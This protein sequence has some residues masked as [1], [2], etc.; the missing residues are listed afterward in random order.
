MINS[1]RLLKK[2]VLFYFC[3]FLFQC[4]ISPILSTQ[5]SNIYLIIIF[6]QEL[7]KEELF[8]FRIDKGKYAYKD[9]KMIAKDHGFEADGYSFVIMGGFPK[10]LQFKGFFR[11]I[12]LLGYFEGID[13]NIGFKKIMIKQ[14]DIIA[15]FRIENSLPI[16]IVIKDQEIKVGATG[17]IPIPLSELDNPISIKARNPFYK[18]CEYEEDR[19]NISN[20]LSGKTIIIAPNCNRVQ[21]KLPQE[22]IAENWASKLKLRN[23]ADVR[24]R[25]TGDLTYETLLSPGF[26][27]EELQI[28]GFLGI[29][30]RKLLVSP[31]EY[32][33][34]SNNLIVKLPVWLP[35][36]ARCTIFIKDV[37]FKPGETNEIELRFSELNQDMKIRPKDDCT[38]DYLAITPTLDTIYQQNDIEIKPKQKE[39]MVL[40]PVEFKG[41]KETLTGKI[42]LIGCGKMDIYKN[43]TYVAK[44]NDA[45][46]PTKIELP[47]FGIVSL[48]EEPNEDDDYLPI[49]NQFR[50]NVNISKD[51]SFDYKLGS[52]F[53]KPGVETETMLT[54]DKLG[55]ELKI[56]AIDAPDQYDILKTF[57]V[58]DIISQKPIILFPPEVTPIT[59]TVVLPKGFEGVSL[60]GKTI[61]YACKDRQEPEK[62]EACEPAE[63]KKDSKGNKLKRTYIT[64]CPGNKN[65]T[66]INIPG[67]TPAQIQ[68]RDGDNYKTKLKTAL[69]KINLPPNAPCSYEIAGQTI[70][71]GETKEIFLPIKDL[72]KSFEVK[73]TDCSYT[74]D[75]LM[76]GFTLESA[77]KK[78]IQQILI[79]IRKLRIVYPPRFPTPKLVNV[80]RKIFGKA[81]GGDVTYLVTPDL[82]GQ[83]IKLSW[84]EG[85]NEISKLPVDLTSTDPIKIALED[86]TYRWPFKANDP[87]LIASANS[88]SESPCEAEPAYRVQTIKFHSEN[89][90]TGWYP[91]EKLTNKTMPDLSSAN[92]PKNLGLPTEVDFKLK[93]DSTNTAYKDVI[94]VHRQIKEGAAMDYLK[95]DYWQEARNRLPAAVKSDLK[96]DPNSK[97]LFYPSRNACENADLRQATKDFYPFIP[98]YLGN[99]KADACTWATIVRGDR[100]LTP[101]IQGREKDGKIIFEPKATTISGRR[102]IIAIA[103]SDQLVQN[104]IGSAIK[105]GIIQWLQTLKA[106]GKSLPFNIFLLN[107]DRQVTTQLSG[108]EMLLLQFSEIESRID[109][110]LIFTGNG[111]N[112]LRCLNTIKRTVSENELK[113]NE[114][115]LFTDSR[116]LPDPETTPIDD[117]Q[118]PALMSWKLDEV[119]V[120]VYT[121]TEEGCSRLEGLDKKKVNIT[122]NS[123]GGGFTSDKMVEILNQF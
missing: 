37:E 102:K 113:I 13:P 76:Q 12:P 89:N 105:K 55:K 24:F 94:L 34:T 91:S 19:F 77:I 20:A 108:E 46:K 42:D 107:S 69:F 30:V 121:D 4:L 29:D 8:D 15:D 97:V 110:N 14:E 51:A 101:C 119:H 86:F 53:L 65:P 18:K 25:K 112:P 75:P 39:F 72:N 16:D 88:I 123:L 49:I 47:G 48:K 52:T 99:L 57:T 115:I 43:C 63:L 38:Q 17:T 118:L 96:Y 83:G 120:T 50:V 40:L 122:C 31:G 10:L 23:E 9:L 41:L 116:H 103:N 85:W 74:D 79:P 92:W 114:V 22:F 35:K 3:L 109:E 36:N 68:P 60:E 58:K 117:M 54:W 7:H 80:P 111:F 95:T 87:W 66:L 64:T 90:D 93:Q 28:S 67:L 104:G 32:E 81:K 5:T 100:K 1:I 6:P 78:E 73:P 26:R 44:C 33:I 61:F 98:G 82:L 56:D 2:T 27:P 11:D 84:G 59:F 62:C 21:I 71:A 106:S 70:K 45:F